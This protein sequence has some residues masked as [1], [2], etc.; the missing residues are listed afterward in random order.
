MSYR[1]E[2]ARVDLNGA[3][4]ELLAAVLGAAGAP[5]DTAARD[6]D[7]ILAWRGSGDDQ[8]KAQE[9]AAYKA[10]GL[11]YGPRL[12]PFDDTLELSLVSRLSPALVARLLPLV[13]VYGG[14]S[15]IDVANADP[16][17]LSALPGMTPDLLKKT[18]QARADPALDPQDLMKLLAPASKFASVEPSKALRAVIE[19]ELAR[20]RKAR[21]EVVFAIPDKSDAPYDILYWRDD[22]DGPL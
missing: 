10:A 5:P 4:K 1:S 16:L 13:T 21:A 11:G 3:P 17:I 19:V 14:Q 20:G 9:A 2:A 6:A 12:G 18:L 15:K 22:F 7:R 8:S